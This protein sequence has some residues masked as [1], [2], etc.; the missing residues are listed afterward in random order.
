MLVTS[1]F[2]FNNFLVC[3]NYTCKSSK[4]K[5]RNIKYPHMLDQKV[6]PAI[7]HSR[8]LITAAEGNIPKAASS[9]RRLKKERHKHEGFKCVS[10]F[11]ITQN[12]SLY[13]VSMLSFIAADWVRENKGMVGG[14]I[15]MWQLWQEQAKCSAEEH[16][17]DFTISFFSLPQ[18][19]SL[20]STT[21]NIYSHRVSDCLAVP[22]NTKNATY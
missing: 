14:V 6:Q 17:T 16:R 3:D 18:D 2:F 4:D 20:M 5:S 11:Y 1:F 15:K 12:N 9:T 10:K 21:C 22:E 19:D 13:G 8:V 7:I